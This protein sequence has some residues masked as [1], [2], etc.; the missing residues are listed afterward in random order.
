LGFIG[1]PLSLSYAMHGA[2]VVGLDVLPRLVEDINNGISHHLEYYEGKALSDILKEQLA[3]GR[4]VAVSDYSEAARR[5]DHYIIT[6][7]IPIANGEANLSHLRSCCEELAKVLKQGDTVIL[8]STVVPGSTEDI[9]KPLLEKSGL[10]AGED[11]YL[12]YCSERIAEGRAFEE[13]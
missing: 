7:G 4:F 10:K 12:A 6:V 3:A 11:F 13:F 9:V 8:R 5:V 2:N 1:L